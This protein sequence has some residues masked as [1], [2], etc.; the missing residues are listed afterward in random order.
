MRQDALKTLLGFSSIVALGYLPYLLWNEN[1]IGFLPQYLNENFNLGLAS[2]A[3]EVAPYLNISKATF[4]NAITF[5]GIA[6]AGLFYLLKP[7]DSGKVALQRCVWIIAWFTLF[8]QNLFPWYLLWLL[9]LI[10]LFLEPGKFMGFKP[11]PLAA[12]F[13]FSGT[14]ALAYTFF[15]EWRIITWV[16]WVEFLP[17][18]LMIILALTLK[19]IPIIRQYLP[20]W[21]A[22][23]QANKSLVEINP[24]QPQRKDK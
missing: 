4:A 24:T 17:L 1:V 21:H 2:V 20:K 14:I 11:T 7:A 18:Y 23:R 12:W 13:T 15:I 10:T 9:P 5:G 16:Q 8:T 19:S 22:L 3:F 6:V